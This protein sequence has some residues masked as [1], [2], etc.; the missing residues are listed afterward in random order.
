[1]ESEKSRGKPLFLSKHHFFNFG[2]G[3]EFLANEDVL[4]ESLEVLTISHIHS[5][6]AVD[7]WEEWRH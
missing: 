3:R 1:M 2:G 5:D 4:P 6:W 7:G